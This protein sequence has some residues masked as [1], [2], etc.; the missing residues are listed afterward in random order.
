MKVIEKKV[1]TE[2][3]DEVASG[4]KTYKQR[5]QSSDITSENS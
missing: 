5:T 4:Q 1:L 2:Y 3:F